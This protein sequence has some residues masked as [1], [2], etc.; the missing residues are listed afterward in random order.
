MDIGGRKD[1]FKF[2]EIKSKRRAKRMREEIF[3]YRC[4]DVVCEDT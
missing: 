2:D 1:G 4:G 3:E